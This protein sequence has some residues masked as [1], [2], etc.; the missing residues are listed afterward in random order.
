VVRSRSRTLLGSL[1]DGDWRPLPAFVGE[2]RLRQRIEFRIFATP[3]ALEGQSHA[4]TTAMLAFV[5]G[6]RALQRLRHILIPG[7]LV[8]ARLVQA[9][10][11]QPE[12]PEDVGQRRQSQH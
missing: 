3:S 1:E 9:G 2:L 11:L 4:D 12:I 6:D 7:Q 10:Q 8:V 5:V